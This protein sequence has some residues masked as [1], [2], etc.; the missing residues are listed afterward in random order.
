MAINYLLFREQESLIRAQFSPSICARVAHRAFAHAYGKLL[1]ESTYPHNRFQTDPERTL[2]RSG[3]ERD[4]AATAAWE[5]EGGATR[6]IKH[7]RW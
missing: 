5:N 4:E 3:R 2:L 1:V 6:K 7:R